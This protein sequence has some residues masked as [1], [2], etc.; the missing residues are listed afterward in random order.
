M[1][2]DLREIGKSIEDTS[3]KVA[4]ILLRKYLTEQE[5][6][7]RR[8]ELEKQLEQQRLLHEANLAFEKQKLDTDLA[9]REKELDKT[10]AQQRDLSLRNDKRQY[11]A[12]LLEWGFITRSK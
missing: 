7:A 4:D 11:K 9:R 2:I 8:A 6:E 12:T 5:I 3:S 10:L 1:A